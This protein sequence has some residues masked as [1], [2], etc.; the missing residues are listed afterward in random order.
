MKNIP[1]RIVLFAKD[2]QTMASGWE[3][4]PYCRRC[5]RELISKPAVSLK[6]GWG[7]YRS[8]IPVASTLL[9]CSSSTLAAL[10]VRGV[11]CDKRFLEKSFTNHLQTNVTLKS[12]LA[13]HVQ[14]GFP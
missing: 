11:T 6:K 8:K 5:G 9:L 10:A 12:L 1:L 4:T 3:G 13:N 2:Y 7:G 14:C